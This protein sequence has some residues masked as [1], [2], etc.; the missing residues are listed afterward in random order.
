MK[1]GTDAVLL[2]AWASNGRAKNI[3][4]IGTGSGL[5]ALMMAQRNPDAGILGI[6]IHKASV[7]EANENFSI[8]PWAERLSSR[9]IS[10]QE[11]TDL[12]EEAYDLII[13]NPP[14]FIDSLLPDTH[15][16]TIAHH[17][18]ELPHEVIASSAVKLLIE[19]GS[20]SMVLPVESHDLFCKHAANNG[21][22]LKRK[23]IITPVKGKLANRILSE[24]GRKESKTQTCKLCIRD[25]SG[26]YTDEYIKLTKD[27]Y[28]AY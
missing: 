27:F 21:L 10:L 22:C 4:D 14:F 25:T 1:V 3:L 2:G 16:K 23:M 11:Y 18:G 8:S 13:S 24:W 20:L 12:A 6:D 26:A 19:E 9:E 15:N 7:A 17:N 28:L 5:L